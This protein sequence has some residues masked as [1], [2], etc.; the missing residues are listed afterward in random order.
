MPMD[1]IMKKLL[2]P[3][4]ILFVAVLGCSK[5]RELAG[6]SSNSSGGGTGGS[7]KGTAT[8]GADPKADVIEASKKFLTIPSYTAHMQ[9][10]G[11][12]GDLKYQLEYSQP[13][14]YHMTYQG[15]PGSGMEMIAIGSNMYTKMG[16]KWM[17]SPGDAK[18]IG[19]SRDAF[20]DEGLKT[21]SD[22]TFDGNDTVDGRSAQ[23]YKYKNVT[24]TGGFGYNCKMWVSSDKGLPMKLVCEYDNG[25][26]KQMTV[27]Y[28]LETPVTIEA[29][30]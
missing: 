15:G 12:Q 25:M 23:V 27:T 10:S 30:I 22:V 8:S 14:K 6:G 9:G 5:F 11:S 26:L 2:L 1:K 3:C 19:S 18:A 17:K 4:L 20:T 24:P 21:L 29:P 13:D 16:G 28:D 7:S